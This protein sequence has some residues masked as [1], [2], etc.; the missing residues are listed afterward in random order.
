MSE[1][2]VDRFPCQKVGFFSVGAAF[3]TPSYR[4]SLQRTPSSINTGEV[5]VI[6]CLVRFA[7]PQVIS[8]YATGSPD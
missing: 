5:S 8:G 6:L 3:Q 2:A 1:G 4:R 7:H